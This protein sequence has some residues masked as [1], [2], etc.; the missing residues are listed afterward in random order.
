TTWAPASSGTAR[1]RGEMA[2][3]STRGGVAVAVAFGGAGSAGLSRRIH[4]PRAPAPREVLDDG[5]VDPV[6]GVGNQRRG[7]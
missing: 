6:A 7:A 4:P 1:K 3:A 5:V 2:G